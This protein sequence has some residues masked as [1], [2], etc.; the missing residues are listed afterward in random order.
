MLIDKN[1]KIGGKVSIIDVLAAL[2]IIVAIFG[3]S[4]RFFSTPAK[5][6]RAHVK[7]KFVIEIEDLRDYSVEVIERKGKVVDKKKKDIIGEIVDVKT[8]KYLKEEF[9]SDGN[10]V[11]AEVPEKYSV[12]VTIE[13][14]GKES[15]NGYFV[16]NDTELSV[17]STI[18]IATKY[19]NSSGKVK[20]IERLE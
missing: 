1:G 5:N 10:L 2:V 15:E 4:V 16:G 18:L 8:K 3:I 7:L 19:V 12:D 20:S 6:A 13:S 17:G 11:Y 14:D 9:D